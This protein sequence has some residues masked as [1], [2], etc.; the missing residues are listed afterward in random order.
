MFWYRVHVLVWFFVSLILIAELFIMYC[1]QKLISMN[2][3]SFRFILV[4]SLIFAFSSS[5][6]VAQEK[7]SS[8]QS[9]IEVKKAP[10]S[11]LNLSEPGTATTSKQSSLIQR[12]A[13][14]AKQD[15]MRLTTVSWNEEVYDFGE[16][17][18]GDKVSHVFRF[19]NTGNYPLKLSNVKPSCGCTSPNWSQEPIQ[20]GEEGFVEVV[21]DS[22]GKLGAQ[23]KSITVFLNSEE[24]RKVLRFKGFISESGS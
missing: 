6:T 9:V 24:Q 10:N 8:S 16:I 2:T 19:S 22:A 3:Y 4:I 7:P 15:T 20:P 18:Q 5:F 13:A 11:T 14:L 12:P 17:K 23:M 1:N 21:F